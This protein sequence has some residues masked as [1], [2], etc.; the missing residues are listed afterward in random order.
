[1]TLGFCGSQ[2][3]DPQALRQVLKRVT[4]GFYAYHVDD[5]YAT[6]MPIAGGAGADRALV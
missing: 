1:M 2:L 6:L 5:G 4:L 3:F